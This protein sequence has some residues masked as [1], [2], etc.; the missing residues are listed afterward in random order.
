VL[1]LSRPVPEVG[2]KPIPSA[3]SM[4]GFMPTK[5]TQE[6][7]SV[8][9]SRSRNALELSGAGESTPRTFSIEGAQNLPAGTYS[10]LLKQQDPLWYASDRYFTSR[11]LEIPGQGDKER[12]RRGALGSYALFLSGETPIHAGPIWSEEIGGVR[13]DPTAMEALFAV[14]EVGAQVEVR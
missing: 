13:L 8:V 10:V 2:A 5:H 11:E 7:A 12:F 3:Q 14:I 4:L 1:A 6:A 9:I